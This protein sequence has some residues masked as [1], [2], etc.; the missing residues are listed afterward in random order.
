MNMEEVGGCNI[1]SSFEGKIIL[2]ED[3]RMD[4]QYKQIILRV[5]SIMMRLKWRKQGIGAVITVGASCAS[6]HFYVRDRYVVSQVL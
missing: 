2:L 6:H 4:P 5:N 1:N 3:N